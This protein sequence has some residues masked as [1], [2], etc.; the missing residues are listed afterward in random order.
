M[1]VLISTQAKPLSPPLKEETLQEI[2]S[3]V[4]GLGAKASFRRIMVEANVRG[5]LSWHRTLRRYLDLLV[6][7]GVLRVK[8]KD[9]GSVNPQQTY[10]V[11]SKKPK[12]WTGVRVLQ[13]HGLNWDT[14]VQGPDRLETDLAALARAKPY[15]MEGR[16]ILATGVED[17]LAY[18]LKKDADEQTGRAELVVA[19][20]A[21]R[22]V[23][24]A[25]LL[26]R[27]ELL[28]IGKTTRLLL[29]KMIRV[30]N[31]FVEDMD[32]RTFLETR[33]RFL[34]IAR[35]YRGKGLIRL[36]DGPGR[37]RDGLSIVDSISPVQIVSAAAKQLGASG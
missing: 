18:E 1:P 19:I 4:E 3:I 15:I 11:A 9:V 24:L 36:L 26:K 35:V 25:Y 22:P 21:T 14:P 27:A 12:L 28:Q 5:V 34:T 33:K 8:E 7:A 23:D 30:Y 20:L 10:T 13:L 32:A 31:G 16:K 17:T 29:R 6:Q 37:G 2:I